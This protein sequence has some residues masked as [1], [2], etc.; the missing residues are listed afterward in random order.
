MTLTNE[1]V[2]K[3]VL[4]VVKHE[5]PTSY[6]AGCYGI[7]VRRVQQQC[8]HFRDTGEFPIRKIEA[9]NPI[10]PIRLGLNTTFS[11]PLTTIVNCRGGWEWVLEVMLMVV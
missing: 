2:Q 5:L 7:G 10:Y 11:Y 6:V 8:K 3:L 1:G 9:D 4:S